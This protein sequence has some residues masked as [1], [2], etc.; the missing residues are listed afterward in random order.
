MV[1]DDSDIAQL[2]KIGLEIEGFEVDAYANAVEVLK[3]FKCG[4][5]DV[6]ISDINMPNINGFELCKELLRKDGQV[7]VFFVSAFPIYN[8]DLNVQFPNLNHKHFIEKPVSISQLI[9]TID[10]C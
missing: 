1:D 5:Y 2:F 7:K 8:N 10:E 4:Y 6:I 9:K 3:N